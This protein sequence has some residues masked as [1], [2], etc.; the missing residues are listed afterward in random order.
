M[1]AQI[2]RARV[3]ILQQNANGFFLFLFSKILSHTRTPSEDGNFASSWLLS[4]AAGRG[5]LEV[6][7]LRWWARHGTSQSAYASLWL[8]SSGVASFSEC[9]EGK[10]RGDMKTLCHLF[11]LSAVLFGPS[12]QRDSKKHTQRWSSPMSDAQFALGRATALQRGFLCSIFTP[13]ACLEHQ[14]RQGT[15]WFQDPSALKLR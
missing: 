12:W 10:A 3:Q 5:T 14:N 4:V 2:S 1:K 9:S 7:Q 15:F 6:G 13:K 8:L 11:L